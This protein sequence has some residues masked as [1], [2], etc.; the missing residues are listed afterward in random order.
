MIKTKKRAN[1]LQMILQVDR[2]TDLFFGYDYCY[3]FDA[4]EI[5]RCYNCSGF[6]LSSENCKNKIS[7]P[8]CSL[9]H[10]ISECKSENFTCVNCVELSQNEKCTVDTNHAAWDTQCPCYQRALTNLRMICFS[11]NSNQTTLVLT[12]ILLVSSIF[13]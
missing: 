11:N 7:C 8:K 13:L 9:D 10:K 5:L 4:I 3:T 2:K 6:N 1:L 12:L